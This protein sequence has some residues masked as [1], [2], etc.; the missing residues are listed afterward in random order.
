M[1]ADNRKSIEI[2]AAI[3]FLQAKTPLNANLGQRF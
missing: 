1:G 3:R 2:K